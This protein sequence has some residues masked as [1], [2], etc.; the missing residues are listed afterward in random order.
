MWH[1]EFEIANEEFAMRIHHL[2]CGCMCPVGGALFDGFSKGLSARLA[3]H[4]LLIETE[5]HGLVLV[6]TGFGTRD[7]AQRSRRLSPFFRA[8]NNIQ[9]SLDLTALRQIQSLGFSASDVRHIVLTH[10]DFD[11]AGGLDDFPGA[12]VHVLQREIDA[13]RAKGGFIH[14]NRYRAKQWEQVSDWRFYEPQGSDWFGFESVRNLDGLPP[15]VLLVPL[16]GHTPGHAGVAI[17]DGKRWILHAGDAYFYRGEMHSEQR[18]CTPGLR[19]YQRMMEADRP[20][21][22]ANQQRLRQLSLARSDTVSMFCSHDI[23]EFERFES[24]E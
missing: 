17:D 23:K 3:C 1:L 24:G 22:L 20:A 13:A 5:S 21:R 16:A 14:R 6:D 8:L 2:N 19:F 15:E 11:H 9:Y 10:L 4:C 7:I 18:H 12:R